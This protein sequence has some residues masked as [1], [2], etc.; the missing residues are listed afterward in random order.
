MYESRATTMNLKYSKG[1]GMR[2]LLGILFCLTAGVTSAQDST[3]AP[4]AVTGGLYDRPYLFRPSSRIAVGGYAEM[5]ARAGYKQ[6]VAEGLSLEAR[7]FNIFLFSS[8]TSGIKFTSELEFE[9]GTEE[10]K[11]EAALVDIEL[12]D[13]LTLRG[14]ILLSP[15]GKFN[16]AH[17]S[18][19]NEF[20]DR[21]LVSTLIIPTTL[22]EAGFGFH[23][24][25]YPFGLNR[26]TYELYI[27]NGLN[28]GVLLGGDGTSIPD[29][30]PE[31]FGGDNNGRP[32][33]VGRIAVMP[34]FGGE[35][36]FSMHTGPYNTFLQE[37]FEIDV[38]RR[39]TILAVDGEMT[40]G[41]LS[42]KGEFA[43]AR[44]DLPSSL[45]GLFA[46]RQSGVYGQGMYTFARGLLPVFPQSELAFGVRYDYV[47]FDTDVDGSAIQR[48]TVGVNLR[49]VPETLVK[50]DYQH[51]WMF[52][53]INNETRAAAIQF[54]LAT[55]F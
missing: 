41:N 55:Y 12:H 7:R 15:I 20:N 51:N 19:R 13:A 23:G 6:G 1:N 47:N 5:V 4:P 26:L 33:V 45:R 16:I 50:L 36:G 9:H 30:R 40:V 46:E 37:G 32:S 54:G 22:S 43:H 25:V 17:D 31:S 3:V 21:P 35:F 24:F 14:G 49:L 10:I 53:R 48:L 44:I 42:L 18:P 11:L 28:D 8:I 27:V 2:W 29:G 39:L 52:D 34:E 38:K